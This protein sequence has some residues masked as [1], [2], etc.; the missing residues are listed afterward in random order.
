MITID[1]KPDETSLTGLKLGW[2]RPSQ[3]QFHTGLQRQNMLYLL[4]FPS[5]HNVTDLKKALPGNGSV[6]NIGETVF[7]VVCAMQQ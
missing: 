2:Q 7:Y 5:T 4:S 3:Q 1:S 6:N